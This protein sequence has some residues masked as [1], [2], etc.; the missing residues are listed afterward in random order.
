[1]SG[2]GLTPEPVPAGGA[3][4]EGIGHAIGR[5][6]GERASFD[7]SL[8][9][10]DYKGK[11][12]PMKSDPGFEIDDEHSNCGSSAL[13]ST[14]VT[15]IGMTKNELGFDPTGGEAAEEYWGNRQRA[16]DGSA[17][18]GSSSGFEFGVKQMF[19]VFSGIGTTKYELGPHQ[20]SQ[21]PLQQHYEEPEVTHNLGDLAALLV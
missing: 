19:D 6:F 4:D 7:G 18:H 3:S 5:K 9:C 15:G 21:Q 13:P 12:V 8:V 1:M 17:A 2:T 20:L 14:T 16:R 11:N 10:D